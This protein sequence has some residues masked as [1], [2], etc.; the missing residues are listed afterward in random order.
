MVHATPVETGKHEGDSVFYPMLGGQQDPYQLNAFV[1]RHAFFRRAFAFELPPLWQV[2]KQPF[3]DRREDP[4]PPYPLFGV[5]PCPPHPSK[6]FGCYPETAA[7]FYKRDKKCR[8][9]KGLQVQIPVQGLWSLDYLLPGPWELA[10]AL[11]RYRLLMVRTC[12]SIH[13]LDYRP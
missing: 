9:R 6:H 4:A 1:L 2:W 13:S 5:L 12:A 11:A 8:R 10:P 7:C 3:W